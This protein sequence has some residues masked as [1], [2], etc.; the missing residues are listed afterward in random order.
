MRDAAGEEVRVVA[1]RHRHKRRHL[2]ARQ[3]VGAADVHD[4]GVQGIWPQA[5]GGGD[6]VGGQDR[7]VEPIDYVPAQEGAGLGDLL[8]G[9]GIADEVGPVGGGVEAVAGAGEHAVVPVGELENTAAAEPADT[10]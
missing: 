3:R 8:V 1:A 5:G 6:R 10:V 7:V 2:C 9:L 4:R